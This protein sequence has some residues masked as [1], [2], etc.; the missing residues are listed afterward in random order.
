[1]EN[2]QKS[3]KKTKINE[4]PWKSLHFMIFGDFLKLFILQ[5]CSSH[6]VQI[7]QNI[8]RNERLPSVPTPSARAQIMGV[9]WTEQDES[10]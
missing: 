4:N 8:H 2:H 9:V 7:P 10:I 6:S 3:I 1:M 5:T